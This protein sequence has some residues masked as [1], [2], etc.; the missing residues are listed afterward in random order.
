MHFR[1]ILYKVYTLLIDF[2]TLCV[3]LTI[4]QMKQERF[5]DCGI[6]L[7]KARTKELEQNNSNKSVHCLRN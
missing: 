3:I 5:L 6:C 4:E 2:L 7:T 1:K